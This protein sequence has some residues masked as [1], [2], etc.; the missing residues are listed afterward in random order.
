M[1]DFTID[2][3]AQPGHPCIHTNG[4]S[5]KHDTYVSTRSDSTRVLSASFPL[6][7]LP[8][9]N[10]LNHEATGADVN[11]LSR[12]FVRGDQVVGQKQHFFIRYGWQG[13][14]DNSTIL[15]WGLPTRELDGL[16]TG[17]YIQLHW[18]DC[19]RHHV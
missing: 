11:N 5:W 2:K 9:G 4:L 17:D 8:G 1:P 16:R 14:S 7:N 13:G 19:G 15:E 18:N 6:P 3:V 10:I 12:V